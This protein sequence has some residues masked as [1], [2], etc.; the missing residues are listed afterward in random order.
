MRASIRTIDGRPKGIGFIGKRVTPSFNDKRELD[1]GKKHL[2]KMSLGTGFYV[3]IEPTLLLQPFASRSPKG[4][5]A[6]VESQGAA[7]EAG[8]SLNLDPR[9]QEEP[10]RFDWSLKSTKRQ[11]SSP[12]Q[13]P[14]PSSIQAGP[15]YSGLE[16]SAS[17][18]QL[19]LSIYNHLAI[20]PIQ[21]NTPISILNNSINVDISTGTHIALKQ[22]KPFSCHHNNNSSIGSVNNGNGNNNNSNGKNAYRSFMPSNSAS[23]ITLRKPNSSTFFQFS[24]VSYESGRPLEEI[25]NTKIDQFL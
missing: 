2:N 6:N 14:H 5:G 25:K 9:Q 17:L 3:S 15:V 8:P 10:T 19:D 20:H 21:P 22:G 24:L 18:Y 23:K 12:Q 4:E 1:N 7:L 16:N 13:H 11:S